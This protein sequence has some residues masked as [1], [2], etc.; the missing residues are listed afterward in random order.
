VDRIAAVTSLVSSHGDLVNNHLTRYFQRFDDLNESSRQGFTGRFYDDYRI[1]SEPERFTP[2]DILAVASLGVEVPPQHV[3]YLLCGRASSDVDFVRL[4]ASC[5]EETAQA[6][7]WW[8]EPTSRWKELAQLYK[9]LESLKGMGPVKTSK[10]MAVKFPDHVPISDRR[11]KN[12]LGYQKGSSWWS[13]VR[14]VVR[15]PGVRDALMDVVLDS[16]IPT[17][18]L[19]RR[20]DVVL[21]MEDRWNA[22]YQQLKVFIETSPDSTGAYE[23]LARTK[24]RELRSLAEWCRL[25]RQQALS[26]SH[27]DRLEIIGFWSTQ[28]EFG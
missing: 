2:W 20:L 6:G 1:R 19:L 14:D 22:R 21:W 8:T 7:P 23:L 17:I 28:I 12:M 3:A 11:V 18:G 26:R 13:T 27:R 25:Q 4:L 16:G 24:Q 15:H 5:H 10:L 9:T